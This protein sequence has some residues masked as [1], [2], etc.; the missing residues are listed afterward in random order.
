MPGY[1]PRL[2]TST[3]ANDV[4]VNLNLKQQEGATQAKPKLFSPEAQSAVGE[5]QSAGHLTNFRPT[6]Q[7]LTSILAGYAKAGEEERLL[8]LRDVF[9]EWLLEERLLEEECAPLLKEVSFARA[10]DH[11]REHT[12][13][14]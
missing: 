14:V 12:T 6:L 2:V 4:K 13:A 10:G 7:P 11:V 1:V 8:E 3:R 5:G 9:E